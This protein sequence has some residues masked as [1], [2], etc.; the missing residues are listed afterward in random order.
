MI[1]ERFNFNSMVDTKC[2]KPLYLKQ[3]PVIRSVE[4]DNIGLRLGFITIN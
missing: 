1:L 3:Q 2:N 4:K